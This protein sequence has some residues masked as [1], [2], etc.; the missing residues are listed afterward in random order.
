[1]KKNTHDYRKRDLS[2]LIILSALMSFA[3]I[4]TDL[5]LP[6][7]PAI[8]RDL[9]ATAGGVEL[10]LSGFLIGFSLGQLLWGPIGDRFGRRMPIVLGL[11]IFMVG[12]A[13]CA[14]SSTMVQIVSWRVVQAI[15]A[16]AGPVLARAMVRDLYAR[17]RSAQML[18]TLFLF[19]AAAPLSGPI[20]G[21]QILLIGSWHLIFWAMA[22]LGILALIG[23]L[24]LPETLPPSARTT[25]PLGAALKGYFQLLTNP[26]MMG[27]TLAIAFYYGGFYAFIAG[28]PFAYIDYYHVSPQMYG[29]LFSVNIV[30]VMGA[31]LI[32]S[33]LIPRLGSERL[34]H[35]GTGFAA[36]SGAVMALNAW[37]GWGGI[38]GLAIPFLFYVA[39]NGFITANAVAGALAEVTHNAGACSSL[40]GAMQYGSG[41]FSAALLA[42]FADGTPWPMAATIGACAIC[43]A[44]TA[45]LLRTVSKSTSPT[46]SE[47]TCEEYPQR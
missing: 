14:L 21:G 45:V 23:T 27:Y 43:C 11:I 10:T 8:A 16:C 2:I 39:M 22:G 40:I 7:M 26:R 35:F 24:L 44:F 46:T 6:A 41:I 37:F 19:M 38:A 32:N 4:S 47:Y 15:G 12:S 20:L 34:F 13:G 33:R 25:E 28:T 31:N 17:E 30:G 1:M 9:H 42:W 18:S 36:L 3:S 5:Y 29:L